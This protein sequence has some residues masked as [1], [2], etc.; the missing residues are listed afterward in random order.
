MF[1][2]YATKEEQSEKENGL[3]TLNGNICRLCVCDTEEEAHRQFYWITQSANTLLRLTIKRIK[4]QNADKD[5]DS[6]E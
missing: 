6:E 3:Q 5:Y 4:R 2:T 1:K